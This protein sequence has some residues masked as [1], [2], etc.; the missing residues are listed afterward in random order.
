VR[1]IPTSPS[2]KFIIIDEGKWKDRVNLH[3]PFNLAYNRICPST[4]SVDMSVEVEETYGAPE[5]QISE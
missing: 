5:S 1:R 2:I 4:L 3:L